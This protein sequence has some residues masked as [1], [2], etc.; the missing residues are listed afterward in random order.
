VH[1]FF[2]E[3]AIH[4]PNKYHLANLEKNN[5]QRYQDRHQRNGRQISRPI[6][7]LV[8]TDPDALTHHVG[9][10]EG[11]GTPG[12]WTV[13]QLPLLVGHVLSNRWQRANTKDT[14]KT[15]SKRAKH[16]GALAVGTHPREWILGVNKEPPVIGITEQETAHEDMDYKEPERDKAQVLPHLEEAKEPFGLVM[17]GVSVNGV[18]RV[19]E[20]AWELR[21]GK[22]IAMA[23]P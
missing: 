6:F 9:R 3:T 1:T 17:K 12:D 2:L 18:R 10:T 19:G 23:N 4:D 16:E 13:Y 22:S 20:D 15:G 8:P 5:K 7:L 11:Q 21:Y 14:I